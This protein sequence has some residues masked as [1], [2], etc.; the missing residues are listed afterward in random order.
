MTTVVA[1]AAIA[2]ATTI[3]RVPAMRTS[4]TSSISSL[5]DVVL[6]HWVGP[7][8]RSAPGIATMRAGDDVCFT[9]ASTEM[10]PFRSEHEGYMGNYGNTVDR[11]YHRAAVVMWPRD[12]AFE[13]RAKLSPSWAVDELASHVEAGRAD[14]ARDK[15][16]GSCPP[17]IRL[18][19]TS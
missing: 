10:A 6:R 18:R 5:P 19:R 3:P 13:V 1:G 14:E 11:W 12:L 16:K 4:T 7:D 8:G 17:G 9:R 15:A 2:V